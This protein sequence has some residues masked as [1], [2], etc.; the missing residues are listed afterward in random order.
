M[1]GGGKNTVK[2]IVKEFEDR[3]KK[4]T[5]TTPQQAQTQR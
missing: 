5:R 3:A 2:Q 4:E 1:P